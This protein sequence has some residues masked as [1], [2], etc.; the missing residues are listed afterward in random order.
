MVAKQI[1]ENRFRLDKLPPYPAG[2]HAVSYAFFAVIGCVGLLGAAVA[3]TATTPMS[4]PSGREIGDTLVEAII[5][6]ESQGDTY[7]V[8]K[9]GE[10]GLMQIKL[11]TW[12]EITRALFGQP[13]PFQKAFDPTLNRRIGRSYLARLQ[14]QLELHRA[15]WQTDERSLIIAA[16]NAGPTLLR[17]KNFA[18]HQLPAA[19]R[20]YVE[21]VT[22]LH[23]A[24]L[25]RLARAEQPRF[26]TTEPNRVRL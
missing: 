1:A 23:D 26:I 11:A 2:R 9:A 24:L 14:T 4:Q 18:L 21:R 22:N 3:Q 16:F 19:T 8:G 20:D 12:R 7:R 15:D 25:A 5:L 6:V 17:Q 13:L 10:R